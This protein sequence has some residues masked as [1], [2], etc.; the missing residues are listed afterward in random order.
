MAVMLSKRC[1]QLAP[2]IRIVMLHNIDRPL[3]QAAIRNV[4]LGGTQKVNSPCPQN[5]SLFLN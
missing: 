3:R 2:R 1:D 5:I 4:S